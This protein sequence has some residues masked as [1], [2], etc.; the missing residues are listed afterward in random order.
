MIRIR[1]RNPVV[2]VPVRDP[3]PYQKGPRFVTLISTPEEFGQRTQATVEERWGCLKTGSRVWC[4]VH[5]CRARVGVSEPGPA[6]TTSCTANPRNRV[7][8]VNN[9]V[10][11]CSNFFSK[12][13][14]DASFNKDL[15]NEPNFDRIHL[16]GHW[17]V[18]LKHSWSQ[19]LYR[20]KKQAIKSYSIQSGFEYRS[21]F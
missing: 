21:S 5:C 20:N 2:P 10:R 14:R 4:G 16:G 3:D 9:A 11:I 1:I 18:P 7:N 6:S 17:T 13:L 19:S 8:A 15:S 12:S